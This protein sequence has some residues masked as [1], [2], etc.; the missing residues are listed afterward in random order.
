MA[1][2]DTCCCPI[3]N[4]EEWDRK[5]WSWDSKP[6]Y[7]TAYWSFFRIPLT[8]GGAVKKGLEVLRQKNLL[9]DPM[10]MLSGEE[11]MFYST[12]L[13]EMNKDDQSVPVKK[14]SGNFMSMFFEGEY[15]DSPKWIREVVEY[16]MSK[17]KQ[18]KE[19]YFFYATCPKCAKKYGKAQT[20][21]FA[22]VG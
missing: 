4:R 18:T 12:L 6:F 9:K 2:E 10:L 14:L 1:Q 13:I 7:K 5:A 8:Y 3:L 11:S 19:L 17:G 16:C 20:V 21:I 15:R 22:K